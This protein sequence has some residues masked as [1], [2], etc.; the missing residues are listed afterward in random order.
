MSLKYDV[1]EEIEVNPETLEAP[2]A[3]KPSK[4]RQKGPGEANPGDTEAAASDLAALAKE[5]ADH[6]IRGGTEAGIKLARAEVEKLMSEARDHAKRIHEEY[7]KPRTVVIGVKVGDLSAV[8]TKLRPAKMLPSVLRQ[9]AV[10]KAGGCWPFLSGPKG[11]GKTTI[12]E[13]VAEALGLSYACI[14]CSGGVGEQAFLGRWTFDGFVESPFA[15]AYQNG[16]VVLV[17][18]VGGLDASASL[19]LNAALANKEF[20]STQTGKTLKRHPD[21]VCISACNSN[22]KGASAQYTGRD[23]QDA[24]FLDRFSIIGVDYDTDLERE[25]CPDKALLEKLW[26]LRV[27]LQK[28]KA[29]DALGTRKIKNAYLQAQAGFSVAEIF[30]ML[31]AEFD[32]ANRDLCAKIGGEK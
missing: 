1:T 19:C 18:E 13:Q 14:P 20:V 2:A 29:G 7:S 27:E 12:G 26:T 10:G 28:K 4:R 3:E 24:A 15:K 31:A 17:D 6:A 9:V 23:R 8:K 21:F 5:V 16:G 32:A 22:G 30:A 11:S 25:L